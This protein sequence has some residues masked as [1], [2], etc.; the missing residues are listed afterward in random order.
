[1]TTSLRIVLVVSALLVLYLIIRRLKK[2]QIEVMDSIFWLFFS[3]SF[4]LMALFPEIALYFSRLLGFQSSAN[5]VYVYVIA[6]LVMR[7]FASTTKIAMLRKKMEA[8]VQEL[9]LRK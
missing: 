2:T 7:D 6:V 4:V 5:F 9:A 3:F 1:M 8:L